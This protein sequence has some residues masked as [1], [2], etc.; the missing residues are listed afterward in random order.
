MTETKARFTHVQTAIVTLRRGKQDPHWLEAAEYLI[1]HAA[2]DTK[3][4]L[5][6]QIALEQTKNNPQAP[7]A[8]AATAKRLIFLAAGCSL[9][10]LLEAILLWILWSTQCA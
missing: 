6:A 3:L 7:S 5:E 8:N 10:A 9:I 4:L 1:D 2:F